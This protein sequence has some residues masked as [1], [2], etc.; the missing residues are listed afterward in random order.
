MPPSEQ[1]RLGRMEEQIGFI[2]EDVTE[3]KTSIKEDNKEMKDT[4]KEFTATLATLPQNFL[5]RQEADK[6]AETRDKE[7][8][9]TK[10]RITDIEKR[11]RKLELW[12]AGLATSIVVL[13]MIAFAVFDYGKQWF[14]GGHP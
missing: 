4:V 10:E 6:I 13:G 9:E 5:L 7:R 1:E 12:R 2:R 11:V 14:G 8:D 3:I